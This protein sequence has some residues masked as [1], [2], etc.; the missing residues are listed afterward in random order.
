MAGI[1]R[2]ALVATVTAAMLLVAACGGGGSSVVNAPNTPKQIAADEALAKQ[3]VLRLGDLP[4]GYK[5]AP[6]SKSSGGDVPQSVLDKFATCAKVP[7]SKI[8]H[9]MNGNDD[10]SKPSADSP[11]FDLKDASTGVSSSFENNVEA[12]R[13]SED[14]SEPLDLLA[15]KSALE[16]WKDLSRSVIEETAPPG[17]SVRDLSVV[18]LPIGKIGDQSA[19]FE[20][21][22]TL[23]GSARTVKAYL[24][25]Y[26]VRS[27]RAGISLVASGIN[28][29]VD[30]S[31]ALSL[32]RTVVSRLKGAT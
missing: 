1:R 29:R 2:R 12:D 22:V 27:G 25:F 7:K 8:A 14:V 11:D 10:P 4:A 19:A 30:S 20:V 5:G 16:C 32:L 18:S 9:L 15:A 31:L 23:S 13:S 17:G 6:H 26:L 3:A 24:D 21:R 28:Q